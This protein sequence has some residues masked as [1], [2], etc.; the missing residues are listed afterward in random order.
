M[1]E[2]HLE[3]LGNGIHVVDSGYLRA[4]FDAIHI[5]VSGDRA[6]IVDTATARSAPRVLA[7]LAA[8]G[9][10]RDKVDYVV[11]TH[12]HLD[13]AGG[14]GTL[15]AALPNARLTVHPLGARHMIDP[16]K[17]WAGTCEV[18]GEERAR[19]MYGGPTPVPAERVIETPEGATV[20]LAG[21]VLEFYDTPGH[22]RHHVTIRDTQTG[23]LFTGDTFGIAYRD[24][25][26]DGRAFLIPSSTP[27]QFDPVQL[28]RSVDRLLALAPEAVY[29]THYS[30]RGDVPALGVQLKRRIDA[31]VAIGEAHAGAGDE[32]QT[33]IEAAMGAFLIAEARAHGTG[34]DDAQIARLLEVDIVLNSAG[35]VSWLNRTG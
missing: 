14:A 35:L 28:H 32:R 15:M 13:H 26:V 5:V 2:G 10:A 29:L 4:Q 33:R 22:A 17:L 3:H 19:A 1:S 7:A 12:V 25:D 16:A 20:S 34:F 8:L 23:H 11:L 18:Y 30:R 21:R 9:I 31:Y 24:F 27:V 6:A